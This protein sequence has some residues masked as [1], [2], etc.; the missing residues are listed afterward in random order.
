MGVGGVI[1]KSLKIKYMQKT[2]DLSDFRFDA[3]GYGHYKIAYTSPRTGKK[4]YNVTSDMSLVDAIKNADTPK[5]KDLKKLK[6]LCKR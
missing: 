5:Q 1:L 3:F 4:W 6:E 2:I